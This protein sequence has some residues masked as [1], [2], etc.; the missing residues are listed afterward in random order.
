MSMDPRLSA[1]VANLGDTNWVCPPIL[2]QGLHLSAQFF[3]IFAGFFEKSR[4][5]T[6]LQLQCRVTN[7][8]NLLP[9][10]SHK[11]SDK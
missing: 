2:E 3:V 4:T 8:L 1:I 6:L 7:L 11:S 9:M 5:P 10:I